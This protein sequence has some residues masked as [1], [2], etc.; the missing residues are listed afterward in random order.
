MKASLKNLELG[1]KKVSISTPSLHLQ[2]K[3]ILNLDSQTLNSNLY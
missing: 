1:Q 3:V 2:L